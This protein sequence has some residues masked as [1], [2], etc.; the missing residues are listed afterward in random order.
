MIS[1]DKQYETQRDR[2]SSAGHD[3]VFRFW[4]QLDDDA[5]RRLLDQ[6]ERID[7]E[8]IGRLCKTLLDET[9]QPL[10]LDRIKPV[11]NVVQLPKTESQRRERRE[12]EQIGGRIIDDGKVAVVTVA[13]GQGTRLGFD[14]PKGSFP[15]GPVTDR[16]LFEYYAFHL[17]AISDRRG[18]SIPWYIMTSTNYAATVEFF[19]AHSWFGLDEHDIIFFVQETLPA[20][21][22]SG[23]LILDRPDHIFESPNGHGGTFRALDQSGALDDMRRRGIEYISYFQVDNPLV[24]VADPAF[25]GYHVMFG[26]QMS[27]KTLRKCSWDESMGMF[28]VIDGRLRIIEYTEMPESLARKTD[29]DGNLVFWTG[30]PATHIISV[31]FAEKICSRAHTL[32]YHRARKKI[33]YL[34][35]NGNPVVP[36]EPNGFKFEC[37]I[38]DALAET[39]HTMLMEIDRATEYSPVKNAT[40]RASVS[41]SRQAVSNL[42]GSWLESAGIDV[43]RRPDTGDVDGRIEISP[44]FA[45]SREEFVAKVDRDTV[46]SDPMLFE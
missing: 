44:L 17:R 12:A 29:S 19:R 42:F 4:D 36:T 10:S 40:G 6:I 13:G 28:C 27:G 23:E 22:P 31:E 43:P 16:S 2:M 34:D 15:I 18:T 33:P 46:F 39:D 9:K 38:F 30:N 3:E 21:S 45:A 41:E 8:L 7:I 5:R 26:A 32:P 1:L 20:V 25:I 37:F 14:G 35:D 24:L 11:E